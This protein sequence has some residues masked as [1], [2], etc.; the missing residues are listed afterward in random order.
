MIL[1]LE[2]ENQSIF[3]E[4]RPPLRGPSSKGRWQPATHDLDMKQHAIES[5]DQRLCGWTLTGRC[6]GCCSCWWPSQGTTEAPLLILPDFKVRGKFGFVLPGVFVDDWHLLVFLW[7]LQCLCTSCVWPWEKNVN[8]IDWWTSY[9]KMQVLSL[10]IC[11]TYL[12]NYK[13]V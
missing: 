7:R 8:S 13:S 2:V 6:R 3:F 10:D 5:L 11:H 4:L 1:S 12:H 9:F